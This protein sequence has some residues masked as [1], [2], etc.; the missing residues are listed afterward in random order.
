MLP[1]LLPCGGRILCSMN[2]RSLRFL[3]ALGDSE[4]LLLAQ[5]LRYSLTVLLPDL[6]CVPA[7]CFECHHSNTLV[8]ET[9]QQRLI[10][11]FAHSSVRLFLVQ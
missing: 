1:V 4:H 2:D 3:A 9:L 8:A 6:R 11:A 10:A 7:N 5:C